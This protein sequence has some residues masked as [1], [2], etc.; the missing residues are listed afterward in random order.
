MN[1]IQTSE[2]DTIVMDIKCNKYASI[3]SR[4]E[5]SSERYR[6]CFKIEHPKGTRDLYCGIVLKEHNL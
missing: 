4:S 3:R 1:G 2:N 5:Y 6:L